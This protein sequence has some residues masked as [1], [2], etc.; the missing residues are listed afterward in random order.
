MAAYC[1][2]LNGDNDTSTVVAGSSGKEA[3]VKFLCCVL[4]ANTPVNVKKL[5]FMRGEFSYERK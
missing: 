3:E 4:I 5:K 1:D 2:D